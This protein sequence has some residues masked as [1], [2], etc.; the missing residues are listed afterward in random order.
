MITPK[1]QAL[2]AEVALVVGDHSP[3]LRR[4]LYQRWTSRMWDTR[5]TM[6]EPYVNARS[7]SGTLETMLLESESAFLNFLNDYDLYS[8]LSSQP[9][10]DRQVAHVRKA[11]IGSV[12]NRRCELEAVWQE[13]IDPTF[14]RLLHPLS[15]KHLAAL[16][17]SRPEQTQR[18]R[19]LLKAWGLMEVMETPND[20]VPFD[21]SE[22]MISVQQAWNACGGNPEIPATAP[23]LVAALEAM[24]AAE[25]DYDECFT[26]KEIYSL[27]GMGEPPTGV[28]K[29]TTE[30]ALAAIGLHVRQTRQASLDIAKAL[31]FNEQR[32]AQVDEMRAKGWDKLPLPEDRV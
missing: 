20:R 3:R 17:V 16:L 22:P 29:A 9:L 5:K 8:D 4:Q 27:L 14:E 31:A 21:T 6:V 32:L 28:T 15:V 1:M 10:T 26:I 11:L 19:I 12:T 7:T 18:T 24:N 23:E 30:R 13:F 2:I 25:D